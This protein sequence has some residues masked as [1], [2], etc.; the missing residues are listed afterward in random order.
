MIP[1]NINNLINQGYLFKIY[2]STKL[3][4]YFRFQSNYQ[5]LIKKLINLN[6][7]L[8]KFHNSNLKLLIFIAI[9]SYN[10]WLFIFLLLAKMTSYPSKAYDYNNQNHSANNSPYSY[11][12]SYK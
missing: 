2:K 4:A 6:V 7:K 8:D 3:I 1:K 11:Q 10:L 5:Y 12:Q 9:N